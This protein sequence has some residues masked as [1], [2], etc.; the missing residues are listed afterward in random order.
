M[1]AWCTPKAI[2]RE[3]RDGTVVVP[4]TKGDLAWFQ[5]ARREWMQSP[6]IRIRPLSP[7]PPTQKPP[8]ATLSLLHET[9]TVEIGTTPSDGA[10]DDASL[11]PSAR[12]ANNSHSTFVEFG[13]PAVDFEI[14]IPL[15]LAERVSPGTGQLLLHS[16][17]SVSSKDL[18][19]QNEAVVTAEESHELNVYSQ[20]REMI[21]DTAVA[22]LSPRPSIDKVRK[23]DPPV[24]GEIEGSFSGIASAFEKATGAASEASLFNVS[25]AVNE[26]GE[27]TGCDTVPSNATGAINI[28]EHHDLPECETSGF[29]RV[30]P[31]I[32]TCTRAASSDEM[33]DSLCTH[34]TSGKAIVTAQSIATDTDSTPTNISSHALK[35]NKPHITAPKESLLTAAALAVNTSSNSIEGAA[36][37]DQADAACTH[38]S[39]AV[40]LDLA[41]HCINRVASSV[42]SALESSELSLSLSI[43]HAPAETPAIYLSG[44]GTLDDAITPLDEDQIVSSTVDTARTRDSTRCIS[45]RS[46]TLLESV[47]A[48]NNN[49][50]V[51]ANSPKEP[52]PTTSTPPIPS[53]ILTHQQEVG[54]VAAKLASTIFPFQDGMAA[55]SPSKSEKT[56]S[57]IDILLPLK[58]TSACPDSGVLLNSGEP[59][60][61]KD[62]RLQKGADFKGKEPHILNVDSQEQKMLPDPA[63]AQQ[64]HVPLLDK[65]SKNDP[66]F[67]GEIEGC[68]LGSGGALDETMCSPLKTTSFNVSDAPN[69][70]V[71]QTGGDT[72]SSASA[73][74]RASTSK[75][76]DLTS[77]EHPG[78]RQM[79][80]FSKG[81]FNV[82]C[83]GAA[84]TADT[85]DIL[86]STTGK[87][88][89]AT[90]SIA[91]D[92]D[93][94][95]N[96]SAVRTGEPHSTATMESLPTAAT[97]SFSTSS[98]P[99]EDAATVDEAGAAYGN[100]NSEVPR[101]LDTMMASFDSGD[102]EIYSRNDNARAIATTS[103]ADGP[104]SSSP[105]KMENIILSIPSPCSDDFTSG[106]A[107]RD[108]VN[109]SL[110]TVDS[111]VCEQIKGLQ[112]DMKEPRE[113]KKAGQVKSR[114][115][116]RKV[117]NCRLDDDVSRTTSPPKFATGV[118]S[119]SSQCSDDLTAGTNGSDAVNRSVATFDSS[120]AEK[121]ETLYRDIEES[122]EQIQQTKLKVDR[123]IEKLT[124]RQSGLTG[125]TIFKYDRTL[126]RAVEQSSSTKCATAATEPKAPM[127]Q[128]H[129]ARCAEAPLKSQLETMTLETT[130]NGE[131]VNTDREITDVS[132]LQILARDSTAIE[133]ISPFEYEEQASS[134]VEDAL[135]ATLFN[136][137]AH[138]VS[139]HDKVTESLD[140]PT[141]DATNERQ[142]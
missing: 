110:T 92:A 84:S 115:A 122:Q 118:V 30:G 140:G 4:R 117:E 138:D 73:I 105:Y 49:N 88:I 14:P 8:E 127:R 79:S 33:E 42:P 47:T 85:E 24:G 119:T 69:E 108:A 11:K 89:F 27:Q 44:E 31:F 15:K 99:V 20:E 61:F 98:R 125:M 81:P 37:G 87:A 45:T 126:S 86:S 63:V 6:R 78:L 3:F 72:V 19:L 54:A 2:K 134:S 131:L 59:I 124:N 57:D 133:D 104:R 93:S 51:R 28:T 7:I 60:S 112:R 109:H 43:P 29:G 128:T 71:E 17:E 39:S 74:G 12:I 132:T 68:F 101:E 96:S 129:H 41:S 26:A 97:L 32:V 111:S 83:T 10:T 106:T 136:L 103:F 67:C 62:F 113:P 21:S 18:R 121:I 102:E 53:Y 137:D 114:E 107:E 66:P 65:G 52:T 77:S 38:P 94:A 23:N 5:A 36:A 34:S 56:A 120:V 25:D 130:S 100:S 80:G 82:N 48:D 139:V 95:L 50:L 76:T 13:S 35:I 91:T 142:V 75:K 64:S 58:S 22:G 55:L 16:G 90:P 9:A 135:P 141:P 116:I 46:Q 40:S 1:D 123:Q 70:A